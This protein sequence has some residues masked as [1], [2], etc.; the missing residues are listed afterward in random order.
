MTKEKLL[1]IAESLHFPIIQNS[2]K[3]KKGN[4]DIDNAMSSFVGAEICEVVG[5]YFSYILNTKY[6]RNFNDVYKG[7]GLACFENVIGP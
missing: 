2:W 1:W 3:K 4:K 7:D 5:L 6:R